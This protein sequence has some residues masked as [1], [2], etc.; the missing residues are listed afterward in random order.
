[1]KFTHKLKLYSINF[2]ARIII[3]IL[4]AVQYR[5]HKEQLTDFMIS[6]LFYG[7]SPLYMLWAVFMVLMILHLFP[8]ELTSMA[9]LKSKKETFVPVPGYSRYELLKYVQDQNQK[10]WKVLLYWLCFNAVFAFF[11]LIGVL[12]EGD[13][14]ML[15]VFY[16]LCDYIC[17]L[18]FCPFQELVMKNKCC[19][20]CRIYDWGHFMMFTPMLMI[21]SFISWSLFFMSVVVLIHW[22]L[23]YAKYPERFW[24]GSNQILKCGQCQDRTCQYKEKVK[25]VFLNRT[26]G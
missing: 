23:V 18:L 5:T 12:E 8:P 14:F 22:E 19:V 1:M 16:F 13:L 6:P 10:A 26:K 11:Y 9:L 15:T 3:F 24:A 25:E 17:I 2:L 7:I 4:I 21:K 20:N